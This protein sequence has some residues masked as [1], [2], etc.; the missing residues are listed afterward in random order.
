MK[1]IGV[2]PNLD[3]DAD[4]RLTAQWAGWI[5]ALGCIPAA[6]EKIAAR[7]G[8]AMALPEE[9]FFR[10]I[11]LA[12]VLGGDGTMLRAAQMAAL[13]G[14]PLL[15]V[16]LGTLGYLT[17]LDAGS[18]IRP[19]EGPEALEAI[20]RGQRK[21]E[22]RMMLEAQGHLALN[23]ICVS[24]GVASKLIRVRLCINEEYID[25]IRADGL[26]V[27]TPT[28]STAY[29]LSAGGPILKPE[30]EMMVV[31]AIC[32]HALYLRPWVIS[33]DDLIR[34]T[35]LEPDVI[36]TMDGQTK[37][38]LN[39]GDEVL[40][41]RSALYTTIVKTKNAGFYEILRRKMIGGSLSCG[42]EFDGSQKKAR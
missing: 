32:P 27:S 42:E 33:A 30:S 38:T 40:I 31:T 9:N 23:D 26:I 39:A 7:L 28:G 12:V 21:L 1:I 18:D 34:I 22:K 6:E 10:Q 3:K 41:R 19:D 4:L 24:R 25:T 17:D 5:A 8:I 29:N 36:L 13:S 35:A 2:W 14:V 37:A 15:G 20:L 16:N 11:D